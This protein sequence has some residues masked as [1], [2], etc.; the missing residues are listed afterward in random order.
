MTNVLQELKDAISPAQLSDIVAYSMRL[1]ISNPNYK[2]GTDNGESLLIR[3]LEIKGIE[4]DNC[5]I[6]ADLEY[7]SG[8]GVQHLTGTVLLNNGTWLTRDEYDGSEWWELHKV[9]TIEQIVGA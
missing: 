2:S 3:A 1:S 7:D 6:P 8:Y 5:T 9:P 4:I